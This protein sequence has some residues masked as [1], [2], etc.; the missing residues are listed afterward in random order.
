MTSEGQPVRWV[1]SFFLP[2]TAQTHC[3]A[4]VVLVTTCSPTSPT[5]AASHRSGAGGSFVAG[6]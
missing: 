3:G 1:R 2:E 6:V 4:P 5:V